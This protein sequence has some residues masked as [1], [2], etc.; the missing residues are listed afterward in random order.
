MTCTVSPKKLPQTCAILHD[1]ITDDADEDLEVS[2]FTFL[3][4]IRVIRV[5]R[6]S[7]G[8]GMRR[9]AP[10]LPFLNYFHLDWQ[11]MIDHVGATI[12]VAFQGLDAP[13]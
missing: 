12:G 11:N 4:P 2:G 10:S 5:I 6:G 1:S 7:I 13:A 3:L 8:K 9:S